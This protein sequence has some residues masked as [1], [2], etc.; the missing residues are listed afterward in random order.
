MKSG[1]RVHKQ[2]AFLNPL[3]RLG[4]QMTDSVIDDECLA[5]E[6]IFV[7]KFTRL[8]KNK[9]RLIVDPSDSSRSAHGGCL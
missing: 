5:L 6:A 4:P 2:Y 7:E 1:N 9:V 8:E 3:R